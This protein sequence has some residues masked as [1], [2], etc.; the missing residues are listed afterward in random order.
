MDQ[1]P[2]LI[3]YNNVKS[4]INQIR[5]KYPEYKIKIIDVFDLTTANIGP[6]I[7]LKNLVNYIKVNKCTVLLLLVQIDLMLREFDDN[8]KDFK[9]I[10]LSASREDILIYATSRNQKLDGFFTNA[11]ITKS[12]CLSSSDT[13]KIPAG[14]SRYHP[15]LA[16]FII[17]EY[18]KNQKNLAKGLLLYLLIDF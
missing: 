18:D 12:I 7:V 2:S 6:F 1:Q 15:L 10:L 3:R 5:L 14:I 17:N 8:Y 11:S 9:S 13:I 16:S 4:L